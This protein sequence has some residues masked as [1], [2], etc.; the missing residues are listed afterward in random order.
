M[1]HKANGKKRADNGASLVLGWAAS[2]IA[3]W[4]GVIIFYLL[5]MERS[6]PGVTPS[7]VAGSI[8][9]IIVLLIGFLVYLNERQ[10][11]F[12]K[13]ALLGTGISLL[14]VGL[15]ATRIIRM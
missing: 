9:N 15:C 14:I 13:G 2:T 6:T 11:G 7:F 4:V 3:S 12:L 5:E 1:N 8:P 10:S